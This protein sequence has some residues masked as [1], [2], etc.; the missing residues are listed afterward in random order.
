MDQTSGLTGAIDSVTHGTLAEQLLA[1][2]ARA[3]LR[4]AGRKAK[5]HFS[6]I[7]TYRYRQ[8]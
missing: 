7:N 5:N 4:I 1:F 8:R 3:L 2:A 6:A